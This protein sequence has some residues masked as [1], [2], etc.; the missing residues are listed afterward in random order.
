MEKKG[1]CFEFKNN[2]I[3]LLSFFSKIQRKSQNNVELIAR[4]L[5]SPN[6]EVVIFHKLHK[7]KIGKKVWADPSPCS[8]TQAL[9]L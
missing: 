4:H 7:S 5:Y 9:E 2:F 6:I 8:P 1:L 3:E